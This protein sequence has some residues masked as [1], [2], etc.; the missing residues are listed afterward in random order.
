MLEQAHWNGSVLDLGG[1]EF[2]IGVLDWNEWNREHER[3]LL[4]KSRHL[5]ECYADFWSGRTS[6]RHV[7]EL[8]AWEGGSA[9]FWFEAL[10]PDKH[11]AIDRMTRTDSDLFTSYVRRRGVADR[12]KTYW[13]VDQGDERA[14][15]EIVEREFDGRIDLVID[16]AS[17]YYEPTRASLQVLFPHLRPGGLYVIEDWQWSFVGLKPNNAWAGGEPVSRLVFEVL[18]SIGRGRGLVESVTVFYSFAA[19]ERA[20][21]TMGRGL[22]LSDPLA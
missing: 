8:G 12:L 7:V 4:M 13:G 14:L 17:H 15:H 6:P 1:V 9:V 22:Y 2:E 21:G 3:F 5:I 10:S 20:H 11:V 16:D 19:I 18:E